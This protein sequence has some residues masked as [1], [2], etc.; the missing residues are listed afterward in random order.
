MKFISP[1]AIVRKANEYGEKDATIRQI[2]G[3]H[4]CVF[5][6][7]MFANFCIGIVA[8][9][10]GAQVYQKSACAYT[11]G[12]WLMVHGAIAAVIFTVSYI[13][14]TCACSLPC[15]FGS[16]EHDSYLDRIMN[17]V[18]RPFR[19][20][21]LFHFAW[22]CYGMFLVYGAD[23]ETCGDAQFT[24][25]KWIV[26][27]SFYGFLVSLAFYIWILFRL[28]RSILRLEK[29]PS[30]MSSSTLDEAARKLIII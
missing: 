14:L 22:M 11:P 1:D 19:V 30:P 17:Q 28:R 9:V 13:L 4:L 26:E 5:I 7:F 10:I 2:H 16:N 18:I 3:I 25:F 29:P 20:L 8:L 23:T 12:T 24:T 21:E 6:P 15:R 27:Y